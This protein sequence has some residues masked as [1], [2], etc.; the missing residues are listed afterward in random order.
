MNTG[1]D[2]APEV[3]K[4]TP[5]STNTLEIPVEET[6]NSRRKSESAEPPDETATE[7]ILGS[8]W[9]KLESSRIR[10]ELEKRLHL[11]RSGPAIPKLTPASAPRYIAAV[12]QAVKLKQLDPKQANAMLYA[13]QLLIAAS[14][15]E[16]PQ[17]PARKLKPPS[18]PKV[19]DG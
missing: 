9:R 1:P 2:E 14:R 11:D 8:T 5:E 6:V 7:R 19:I 18:G 10:A 16:R 12:A 4:A 3:E 15:M 13:A 17:K